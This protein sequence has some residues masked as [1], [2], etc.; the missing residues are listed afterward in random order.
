MENTLELCDICY[1]AQPVEHYSCYRC[2]KN[3]CIHLMGTVPGPACEPLLVCYT[4]FNKSH[5]MMPQ[6]PMNPSVH[7]IR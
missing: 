7:V 6:L 1:S 3:C 5:H 4:C 2:A